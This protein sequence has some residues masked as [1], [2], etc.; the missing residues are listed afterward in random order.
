MPSRTKRGILD[1]NAARLYGIDPRAR[2]CAVRGDRIAEMR[3]EQGG[4]RSDR[5]L[6]VYGPQTRREFL[7]M[8]RHE[9]HRGSA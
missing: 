2:R 1:L 9:V 3:E 7:A 4:F 5:S 8:R 6:H